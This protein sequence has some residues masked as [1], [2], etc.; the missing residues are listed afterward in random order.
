MFLVFPAEQFGLPNLLVHQHHLAK[1]ILP[2][3][4]HENENKRKIYFAHN[5]IHYLNIARLCADLMA[6][7][8]G[9]PRPGHRLLR[10]HEDHAGRE[11]VG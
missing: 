1:V 3:Y 2:M 8:I 7:T 10:A 9:D 6:A 11:A 4:F 5:H